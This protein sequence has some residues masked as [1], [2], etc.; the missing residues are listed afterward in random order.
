[1]RRRFVITSSARRNAAKATDAN[2]K[3]KT[4]AISVAAGKSPSN[5]HANA[6]PPAAAQ[7]TVD[8]TET[9]KTL[10]HL[11]QEHGYVTYDDINDVLPENVAAAHPLIHEIVAV[12]DG[13]TDGTAQTIAL[14]KDVS[15]IALPRNVGKSRAI[16]AGIRA[17]S[18]EILLFLDADLVGLTAADVTALLLPVLRG[19]ADATISLRKDGLLSWRAIGLDV[20]RENAS[21]AAMFLRTIWTHS[22]NCPDL[23][24]IFLSTSC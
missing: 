2:G 8:L 24:S 4:H 22:N 11:A 13:S 15:L 5:G 3:S 9:V 17:S 7:S 18:C 10:L 19:T 12:D 6:A 1:M 20:F 14:F 21:C 16:C 23:V